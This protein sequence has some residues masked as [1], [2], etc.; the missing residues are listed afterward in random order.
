MALLEADG[1]LAR[2]I[3]SASGHAKMQRTTLLACFPT[4]SRVWKYGFLAATALMAPQFHR[5][6]VAR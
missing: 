4:A 3:M 6:R 2:G 1:C 5:K